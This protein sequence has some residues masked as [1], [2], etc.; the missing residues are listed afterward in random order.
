MTRYHVFLC[1]LASLVCGFTSVAISHNYFVKN[2][3]ITRENAIEFAALVT[4]QFGA[5]FVWLFQGFMIWYMS[6]PYYTVYRFKKFSGGKLFEV[7]LS[8]GFQKPT[9]D[10]LLEA[11]VV[12][13]PPGELYFRCLAAFT[14][15]FVFIVTIIT[16][17]VGNWVVWPFLPTYCSYSVLMTSLLFY[18]N[19]TNYEN[20]ER[21]L[22][23]ETE[24]R[25][26]VET[27]VRELIQN[28]I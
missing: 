13:K 19:C 23:C 22:I 10:D 9:G 5:F 11:P 20:A 25:H 8:R 2:P 24:A 7:I 17:F 14:I 27:E 21:R 3:L 12:V 6:R 1:F 4:L 18:Q 28:K 16:P 26:R 15:V